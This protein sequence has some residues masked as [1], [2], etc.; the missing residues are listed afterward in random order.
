MK[1]LILNR[2]IISFFVLLVDFYRIIL[3]PLKPTCCRFYPS[4]SQYARES[5]ITHG[6]CKGIYL[7]VA[8]ILKC[9][10]FHSGGF[11][12]VPNRKVRIEKNGQ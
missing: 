11:D 2:V 4:C 10:P 5:L 6:L 8:R 1:F 12:P 3:S 9:H 7:S